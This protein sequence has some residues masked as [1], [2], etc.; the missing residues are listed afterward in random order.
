MLWDW[1]LKYK[2][3][4]LN[5]HKFYQKSIFSKRGRKKT[6]VW[7]SWKKMGFQLFSLHTSIKKWRR[8]VQKHFVLHSSCYWQ[9]KFG[10]C[11]EGENVLEQKSTK[12]LFKKTGQNFYYKHQSLIFSNC[13]LTWAIWENIQPKKFLPDDYHWNISQKITKWIS[14]KINT[15]RI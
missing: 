11:W 10:V 2:F 3:F 4:L 15:W 9:A 12:V 13:R 1:D 5:S 7:I 6:L 8:F 14:I